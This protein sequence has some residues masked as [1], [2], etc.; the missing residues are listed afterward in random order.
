MS[1]LIIFNVKADSAFSGFRFSIP[2]NKLIE[3]VT[4]GYK[5]IMHL[6]QKKA[7]CPQI[8]QMYTFIVLLWVPV[9]YAR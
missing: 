4:S 2:Q 8:L 5:Q 1:L 6:P 7:F 9:K 3:K